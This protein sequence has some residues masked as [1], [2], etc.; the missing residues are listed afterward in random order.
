MAILKVPVTSADHI[1]GPGDAPITLVEYGDYECPYCGLAHPHVQAVQRHFGPKLRF[2]FRHFPLSQ[3]HPLAEPAAEV[4]EFAGDQG[5]FWEAHDTL[6]ENQEQLG[7]G[8]FFTLAATLKL[9]T[10]D[11]RTI[12]ET[13]KYAAKIRSDFLGG[14]RSG[15]NGT[16]AFFINGLRHDGSFESGELIPAISVA[17]R[18]LGD[19][20]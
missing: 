8:L 9:P 10:D 4:A 11:L 18:R 16:P 1:R 7:M 17:E 14:V 20:E 2:V 6:Y 12:I 19:T 15:V 5:H 13:Q 3:M